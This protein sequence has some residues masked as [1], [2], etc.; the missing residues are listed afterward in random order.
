MGSGPALHIGRAKSR[1][2][3]DTLDTAAAAQEVTSGPTVSAPAQPGMPTEEEHAQHPLSH[4]EF[5]PRCEHCVR[6]RGR[7]KPHHRLGG[8]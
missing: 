7:H 1:D 4:V 6:S 8:G 2:Q 5:Q 3:V